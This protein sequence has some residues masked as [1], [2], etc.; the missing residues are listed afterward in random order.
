MLFLSAP[1]G[2]HLVPGKEGEQ[3]RNE[4]VKKAA[5]MDV[6]AITIKSLPEWSEAQLSEAR[7]FLDSNGLRVGEFSGFYKGKNSAG[8]LG[9]WEND[10]REY[11]KQL[12]RRQLRQGKAL[13]AHLVGF[14]LYAG[15]K[16]GGLMWAEETWQRCVEDIRWL[17]REAENVGIDVAGHPHILGPL[18]SIDR[19]KRLID[20]VPSPRLKILMDPVNLVEPFMAYR[21]GDL[22]NKIFDELGDYIT[23]LHA[24][25]VALSGGGNVV[26]H[27]DEA[28]PGRGSMDYHTIFRRL[29]KLKQD[30][31]IH[32]EHFPY[33]E[34]IEG[35]QYIRSVA[36][37]VGVEVQ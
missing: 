24:K 23:G 8:G 29:G 27:V 19:Y 37:Q 17:A 3:E 30:I 2:S 21:T 34:T 7:S 15:R 25:D 5:T 28:V 6:K 33:S 36:R 26:A 11:T 12:Y 4:L 32:A 1:I 14:S 10:D 22:I 20:A 18:C 9:A 35:Q 31:A 13:G 16:S